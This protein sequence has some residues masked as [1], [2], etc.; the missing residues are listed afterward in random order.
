M[1]NRGANLGVRVDR[2]DAVRPE[3]RV[4][5]HVHR[6][7]HVCGAGNNATNF[8]FNGSAANGS[9][10]IAWQGGGTYLVTIVTTQFSHLGTF[11]LNI[12]IVS[13]TKTP[14]YRKVS[15]VDVACR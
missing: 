3:H 5:H 10:S 7:H 13:W 6:C 14:F 4:H 12:S 1:I 11:S 15:T 9:T 2:P 8:L